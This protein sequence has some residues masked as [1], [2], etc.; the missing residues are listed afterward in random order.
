MFT[1]AEL[2]KRFRRGDECALEALFERYEPPL[3]QFLVGLL[4]DHHKAEDVLQETF[5]KALER[6]DGVDPEKLRGWLFTVAYRE[7]MLARR[8]SK[9]QPASEEEALAVSPDP[10]PEPSWQAACREDAR[11]L[12]ELLEQ[13]P[14]SQRDVIRARIYEGKRFRDIADDLGC[15]LNTALARMHSGLQRLRQLW[16]GSRV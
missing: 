12:R 15:P 5:I 10:G 13:L 14:P 3:F 4:R 1:D 6:I 16:E 7:A 8:K 9:R 11:R 2:L